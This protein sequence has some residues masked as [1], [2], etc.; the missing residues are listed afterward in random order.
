[1]FEDLGEGDPDQEDYR[2]AF[3]DEESGE[4]YEGGYCSSHLSSLTPAP[5][6]DRRDSQWQ[7]R[8][9]LR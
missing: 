2:S 1:M 9:S 7:R 5:Q 3:Y 4:I 6:L 8:L